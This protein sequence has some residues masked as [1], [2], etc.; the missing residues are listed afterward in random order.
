MYK[1]TNLKSLPHTDKLTDNDITRIFRRLDAIGQPTK[2]LH[3]QVSVPGAEATFAGQTLL[4]L[5][6][7]L[8]G[9]FAQE[10]LSVNI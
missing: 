1:I 4:H 8:R 10:M 2:D 9:I 7:I 6:D 5:V 3:H